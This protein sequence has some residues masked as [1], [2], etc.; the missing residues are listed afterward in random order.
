[1]KREEETKT[2]KKRG[3]WNIS[4]MSLFVVARYI[5]RDMSS[6]LTPEILGLIQ[7]GHLPLEIAKKVLNCEKN[8]QAPSERH[9]SETETFPDELLVISQALAYRKPTLADSKHMYNLINKCYYPEVD[10]S[11]SFRTGYFMSIENIESSIVDASLSW[12]LVEVPEGRETDDDGSIIALCSFT[13]DGKSRRNG[14]SFAYEQPCVYTLL[15]NTPCRRN[16]G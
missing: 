12:L 8:L 3:G 11:E 6:E 2:L 15:T 1:M 14:T 5:S 9:V 4:D 13:T 7:D 16:R 10:G